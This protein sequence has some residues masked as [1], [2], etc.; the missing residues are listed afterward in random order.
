[1]ALTHRQ[2]TGDPIDTLFKNS[3]GSKQPHENAH[4][5]FYR[6]TLGVHG[7]AM[8]I[9]VPT[10]LGTFRISLKVVGQVNAFWAHVITADVDPYTR[11]IYSDMTEHQYT[12]KDPWLSFII[13]IFQG[14]RMTHVWDS[15]FTFS[16][17]RLKRAVLRKLQD[18]FSQ[19]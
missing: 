2:L 13:N 11:R 7:E 12:D 15:Q 18:R 1:M 16:A 8:R 3:S 6:Q 4:I 9:P 17:D 14:L 10:E 5:K 19:F